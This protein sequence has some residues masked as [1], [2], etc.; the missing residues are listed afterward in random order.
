M[1]NCSIN[2]AY[3]WLLLLLIPAFLL[4]FIPYF[5]LS[6]KHRRSRNRVTSIV[7]HCIVMVLA[8]AVL[9]GMTFNY[10]IPNTSNEI[11]LLVDMSDSQEN[12]AENRDKAV[13][14]VLDYSKNNNLKVGVVTF[15]LN[16][17]YAVPLTT[18]T[19]EIYDAYIS[20]TLPDVSATDI[21][22]ALSYARGCFTNPG[23]AKIVLITDGKQTDRN[24]ADTARTLSAQGTTVDVMYVSSQFEG[25]DVQISS[26]ARPDYNIK[27]DEESAL[28]VTV[29]ATEPASNATVQLFDN[30]ELDA[31]SQME[32]IDITRGEQTFVMRHTFTENGLHEIRVKVTLPGGDQI[33]VN[34]E[35]VSYVFIE[36]FNKVLLLESVKG[37][38]Q[39]IINLL[40]EK[41]SLFSL[42]C[43][44]VYSDKLPA[45]VD[46]LRAYD[47]VIL[48]NISNADLNDPARNEN[49]PVD[50]NGKSVFVDILE[51]YVYK[52]GGGMFTVGGDEEDG[53]EPHA[54]V[55]SDMQE[56][57]F[58]DMLPVIAIDNYTP[59]IGVMVIIDRSGSMGGDKLAVARAGAKSCYDAVR[60]QAD[61][62]GLAS[63]FGVMTLDSDYRALLDPIPVTREDEILRAINKVQIANGGT[64]FLGAITRAITSLK[65]VTEVDKRHIIIVS[66]G[67][68]DADQVD[69]VCKLVATAHKE[70]NLTLSVVV[71]DDSGN[72]TGKDNM[73]KIVDAGKDA[74][75]KGGGTCVILRKDQYEQLTLE[76]RNAVTAR[77]LQ[78]ITK[79]S[80]KPIIKKPMSPVFNG[81]NGGQ[82][83][84]KSRMTVKINGFYGVRKR[85]SADLLLAGD[86]DVPLYAQWTYGKGKVGS[87][88][89]D[90]QKSTRSKEFM[91]DENGKQLIYNIV[92]TLMP[93][94]NIRVTSL[95]LKVTEENVYN[96]LSVYY[97]EL[98]EGDRI[99]AELVNVNTNKSVSLNSESAYSSEGD[100]FVTAALD[101]E[102][103]FSRSTFAVKNPGLYKIVA[104]R[105]NASGEVVE[106]AESEAFKAFA[107]SAE[108]DMS[109]DYND[110]TLRQEMQEVATKGKGQ[111]VVDNDDPVEI[112]ERIVISFRREF[113]PKYLFI[114]L[115]IV[116]FLA[117]IAVR[118]F[119]FK[120]PHELIRD[121]K[122]K[123]KTK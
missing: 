105:V 117:D 48:N 80:F 72:T 61:N 76:M 57:K 52:Y 97:S 47:E 83:E 85:Q 17:V 35:Y 26:V 11:I 8:T 4:V 106:Q 69:E 92:E 90:L 64:S 18:K 71:L 51:E 5:R 59:T 100:A 41:D 19:E 40:K 9:S 62:T 38:S 23:S 103:G 65:G 109:K 20:A 113:N 118:K 88:M 49:L 110:E 68:I 111:L 60:L 6:K 95:S 63:Y 14:S 98:N 96:K 25:S 10:E 32:N 78:K 54:Y 67:F 30:G 55:E 66:D 112:F 56:S 45:T 15:G 91:E 42:T 93:T 74:D 33:K 27:K 36:D 29:Y 28:T 121:Y 82:E 123:K 7:L 37:Q 1:S 70:S 58:Q 53:S 122:A 79:D 39:D 116:L 101:S 13:E 114:T 24:A 120:W 104:K 16:Q 50:K 102:S 22:S 94:E 107:Y 86:Y 43:L 115:A 44:D 12:T 31:E 73:Q 21:A 81:V 77:E 89:C 108:Y 75:G 84:E 3:P 46:E 2:F 87:F 34:S 119:K 99:I